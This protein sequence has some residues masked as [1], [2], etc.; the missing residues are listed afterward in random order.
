MK[1]IF[2]T[3]SILVCTFFIKAQTITAPVGQSLTITNPIDITVATGSVNVPNDGSFNIGGSIFLRTK[4]GGNIF[5][6]QNAGNGSLTGSNNLFMGTSS[7]NNNSTGQQNAFIGTFAGYS[8]TTGEQNLFLGTNS[9]Y[10]NTTGNF[11]AFMGVGAGYSNSSGIY[12]LFL[13]NNAG[14]SNTTGNYNSCLGVNAGYT[15]TSGG[16]N[17]YFG[18][19]SGFSS[20]TG[21]RNTF[22]GVNTGYV[23]TTGGDNTYIG[24]GATGTAALTNATA[25]GSGASASTSNTVV[26]GNAATTI[27]GQGLASGVS[28]LRFANITSGTTANSVGGNKV[29]SVDGSGN[30]VLVQLTSGTIN[31]VGGPTGPVVEKTWKESDGYLYNNSTNGVVINGTGLDGNSLIVKGGVLSKEVNVKVEGAESWPDYVFKPSYKRM[32]LD[33]VEKFININGHLP[34]VASAAE[35]ANTG[36]NLNKTDIKLLEKVEELTLYLLEMKKANEAQNAE[37]QN[38]KKQVKSLRRK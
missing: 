27:T 29:L 32:S 1:K 14:F 18:T 6:G 23:N 10:S 17:M 5:M 33:E 35:M 7:G 26:L 2:I 24:Y 37:I 12:N 22:I 38:L 16:S 11:N 20:T 28:G 36:N 21:S 30:V 8:N 3:S 13:G 25:I 19:N 15:S 9:G 34:N 31:S 4:T